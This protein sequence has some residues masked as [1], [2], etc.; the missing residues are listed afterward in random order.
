MQDK[1]RTLSELPLVVLNALNC[2]MHLDPFN[3]LAKYC[4]LYA[5]SQSDENKKWV[6]L[7]PYIIYA[8]R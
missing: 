8:H 7:R 1:S 5:F 3:N 2:Q 6:S 4:H